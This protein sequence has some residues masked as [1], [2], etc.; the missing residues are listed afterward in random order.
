MVSICVYFYFSVGSFLGRLVL[1]QRQL[2]VLCHSQLWMMWWKILH[3]TYVIKPH[4][5]R[6]QVLPKYASTI[7][8]LFWLSA[9]LTVID[10]SSVQHTLSGRNLCQHCPFY[11]V[12]R[13]KIF[14][15]LLEVWVL[16]FE[17]SKF[18]LILF[19]LKCQGKLNLALSSIY[20]FLYSV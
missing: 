3:S 8:I 13:L 12:V 17:Q 5:L 15:F 10:T 16:S 14:F 7:C 18:A 9:P 20:W 2:I 11:R 19:M 4:Y 6:C 1:E